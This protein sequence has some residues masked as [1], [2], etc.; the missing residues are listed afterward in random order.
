MWVIRTI[1]IL[2]IVAIVVGISIYNANERV[3]IDLIRRTYV[4]V[5]LI[6][7]L[8][9]AF[10]AGMAV[11]TALGMTYVVKLHAD[12]RAQRRGRKRLEIEI[13]SLR[14]RAIDDLDRLEP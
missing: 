6:V 13:G 12:L 14:N 5:R 7:V 1:L 8:Y 11:A 10:L 4:D 2:I 9:W 3:T